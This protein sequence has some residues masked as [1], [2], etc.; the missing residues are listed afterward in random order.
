MYPSPAKYTA[1]S[2]SSMEPFRECL[3]LRGELI[4]ERPERKNFRQNF[5]D[6]F[7]PNRS[8]SCKCKGG[9]GE[10]GERGKHIAFS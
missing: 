1:I 4:L 2:V 10:G 3:G 6:L 9:G 5:F 8:I 7:Q